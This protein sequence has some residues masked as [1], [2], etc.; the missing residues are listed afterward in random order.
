MLAVAAQKLRFDSVSF[1][2]ADAQNLPFDD[3]SFDFVV[4]QFGAMF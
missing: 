3:E 4:C 2:Q 1:Q